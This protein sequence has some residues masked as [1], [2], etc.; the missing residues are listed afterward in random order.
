MPPQRSQR[1]EKASGIGSD[2]TSPAP[3]EDGF[4]A[5]SRRKTF[6]SLDGLRAVAIIGV[7]WHHAAHGPLFFAEQ[8][9]KG[10][11]LFFALSGFL[12][13]T[14]LLRERG[15]N[16]NISLR[17]FY[18]R[19]SLRIFPLYYTVLLG[20]TLLVLALEGDSAA[21]SE[22]LHNLRYY[23]TYTS[24][25]FVRLDGR[26]IFYFAWSLATEEQFY[27]VWPS[28]EKLLPRHWPAVVALSLVALW[29][30]VAADLLPLE[31]GGLGQTM[32]LSIAPPICFGVVLA[33]VLYERRG[34]EAL[35]PVLGLRFASPVLL[36]AVFG[37]LALHAPL[38]LTYLLMALLVGACVVREDHPLA[39]LMQSRPVASIGQ[40]SYG[41]YLLHMLA[42]NVADQSLRWLGSESRMLAC[43][44]ALLLAWGAAWVSF[45]NYESRFL[46]LK[47]RFGS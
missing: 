46:R 39:P 17:G 16:G 15:R 9:A 20:Y 43:V 34:F 13:T 35:A 42:L 2:D 11:H 8:G 4:E 31:Q 10:V 40:V 26:V 37:A 25:W 32:L 38:L 45:R 18:I 5:F 30:L 27:L 24:N 22:F 14:L 6:G 21:G 1:F 36:L 29:G 7:V 44:L 12:I 23:L 47:E 28:I 19:R 3:L 41:I 33:H